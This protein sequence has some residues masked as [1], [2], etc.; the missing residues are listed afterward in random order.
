MPALQLLWHFLK[1]HRFILGKFTRSALLS[2]I[3]SDDGV[4]SASLI[5][6][7]HCLIQMAASFEHRQFPLYFSSQL[8]DQCFGAFDNLVGKSVQNPL[9]VGTVLRLIRFL[10]NDHKDKWLSDL[11][12]LT[13]SSRKCMSILAALPEWQP[14]LFSLLSEALEMTTS[15]RTEKTDLSNLIESEQATLSNDQSAASQRLDK[16]LHLYSVLLGH[17]VRSGGDR[18]RARVCISFSTS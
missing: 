3:T 16:C 9:A 6:A 14:C 1:R 4:A 13:Q 18:V 7:D 2:W 5:S 15:S 8:T 11:L 12:A 10:G 17:L